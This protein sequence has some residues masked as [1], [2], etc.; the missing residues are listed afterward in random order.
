MGWGEMRNRRVALTIDLILQ[1]LAPIMP[2]AVTSGQTAD[3]M[4]VFFSG[5][6]PRNRQHFMTGEATAIGWGAAASKDGENA[7]AN[8]GAGDLKNM[9]VEVVES[10]FPLRIER[11][12]LNRDSA[13]AGRHVGGKLQPARLQEET[14]AA[15]HWQYSPA[16]PRR[17]TR[18]EPGHR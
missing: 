7:L 16:G 5:W 9:P 4:N 18:R 14:V 17:K 15:D 2:T 3:P 12:T 10:K 13:G 1:A 8:Y 6:N 11:Y